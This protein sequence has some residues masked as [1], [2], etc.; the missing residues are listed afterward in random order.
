MQFP[1]YTGSA[2]MDFEYKILFDRF[3]ASNWNPLVI[4]KLIFLFSYLEFL[5]N[6][7]KV[8]CDVNCSNGAL[9]HFRF[10]WVICAGLQYKFRFVFLYMTIDIVNYILKS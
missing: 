3:M 6:K 2:D 5:D 4:A 10:E 9:Y 7:K 8:L 1:R